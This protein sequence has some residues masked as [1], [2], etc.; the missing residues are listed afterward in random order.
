MIV[1]DILLQSFL[2][3]YLFQFIQFVETK[4]NKSVF[5]MSLWLIL[6]FLTKPIIYPFFILHILIISYWLLK[7]KKAFLI[8]ATFIPLCFLSTYGFFMKEKTGFFHFSSVQGLNLLKYNLRGFHTF[9]Y[10]TDKATQFYDSEMEIV[11]LEPDFQNWYKKMNETAKDSIKSNLGAYSFYHFYKSARYFIEPGK[12]EID[13][14]TGY[15][16][17]DIMNQGN[18]ESFYTQFEK[19]GWRGAFDYFFNYPWFPFILLI[20]FFNFVRFFGFLI[21][22]Y[23]KKVPLY[24]RFIMAVYVFYFALVTG[25]ISEYTRYYL[26]VLLITSMCAAIG[27]GAVWE[28]WSKRRN[29]NKSLIV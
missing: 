14:F 8:L 24:F 16:N 27:Y 25:P 26:P 3:L 22:L 21:F 28:K 13:L 6:A 9:K 11:N 4:N 7:Q 2:L 20:V 17:F 12:G 5:L 1:P 15:N 29:K 19:N 18:Q 23:N 10:G